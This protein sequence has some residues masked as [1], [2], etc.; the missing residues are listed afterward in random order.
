[1]ERAAEEEEISLAYST[2]S[3]VLALSQAL[4]L[5]PLNSLSKMLDALYDMRFYRRDGNQLNDRKMIL[6]IL[7]SLA[8]TGIFN[9]TLDS[10]STPVPTPPVT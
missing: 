2:S 8:L 4:S 7:Y 10:N 3:T 9:P 1:M 6:L 5:N